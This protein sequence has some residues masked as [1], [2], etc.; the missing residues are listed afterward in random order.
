MKGKLL[1]AQLAVLFEKRTAKRQL[2][3]QAL[4][5][6]LLDPAAPQIFHHQSHQRW[7]LIQPVGHCF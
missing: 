5:P 3:R 2:R 6:G 4:P 7:M 1:V